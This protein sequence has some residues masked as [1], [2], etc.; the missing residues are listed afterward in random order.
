[1]FASPLVLAGLVFSLLLA[2]FRRSR[3]LILSAV[4][5]EFLTLIVMLALLI[6]K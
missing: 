4:L 2:R 6:A 5:V 1:M 3:V